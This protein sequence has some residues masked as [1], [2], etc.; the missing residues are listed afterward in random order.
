MAKIKLQRAIKDPSGENDVNEVTVKDEAKITASDFYDISFNPDGSSTLG[1]YAN[2]IANLT[3]LTELQ[4]DSLHPKD[5]IK[6]SG[7]VGKY[8][9]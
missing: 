9:S 2:T 4:V 1:S 7:E 3:G 5:Y 6:L 8:I